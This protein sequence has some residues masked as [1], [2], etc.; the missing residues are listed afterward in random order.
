MQLISV[1][2]SVNGS[3]SISPS[4]TPSIKTRPLPRRPQIINRFSTCL[5]KSN[6]PPPSCNPTQNPLQTLHCNANFCKPSPL[7]DVTHQRPIIFQNVTIRPPSPVVLILPNS[8][9]TISSTPTCPLLPTSFPTYNSVCSLPLA[10]PASAPSPPTHIRTPATIATPTAAAFIASRA[11]PHTAATAPPSAH[12]KSLPSIQPCLPF[13]S[14]SCSPP[15]PWPIHPY[16][17]TFTSRI[18]PP[19]NFHSPYPSVK[20]RPAAPSKP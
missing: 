20:P 5:S 3:L 8:T 4:Q 16:S 15:F 14:C 6:V 19:V 9:N 11:P 10:P 7:P 17:P 1:Q 12:Q 18:P 2:L 13:S